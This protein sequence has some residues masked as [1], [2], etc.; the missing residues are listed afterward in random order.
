MAASAEAT[1]RAS[2]SI[3]ANA[4]SAVAIVL[5]PGEFM[6]RTPCRVAA[7]RSMLSTPT[8]ARPMTF[9]RLAASMTSAVICVPLRTRIA[10]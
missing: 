2:A 4:S 7:A 8:P 10:S 6:T 5:P 3:R 9:R 1:L